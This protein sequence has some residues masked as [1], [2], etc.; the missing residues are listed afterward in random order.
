MIGMGESTSLPQTVHKELVAPT[1]FKQVVFERQEAWRKQKN[2]P[3][4]EFSQAVDLP[5]ALTN[6]LVTIV[7]DNMPS[8]IPIE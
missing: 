6:N 3:Y 1:G 5:S 7:V 4:K 2:K 8:Y